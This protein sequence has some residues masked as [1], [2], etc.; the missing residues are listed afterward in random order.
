MEQMA[1]EHSTHAAPAATLRH[2]IANELA[3]IIGFTDLLLQD[4]DLDHAWRADLE[5]IR[6][7]AQ[8]ATCLLVE[9][10]RRSV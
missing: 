10:K 5:A 2:D 6:E 8:R 1:R 4:A 3:V 9:M 7:A